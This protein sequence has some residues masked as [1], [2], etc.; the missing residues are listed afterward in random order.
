MGNNKPWRPPDWDNPYYKILEG[1]DRCV[2]SD[3][4]AFEF[5]AGAAAMLEGLKKEGTKYNIN[6]QG[7]Y[8]AKFEDEEGAII[9][10]DTA[11]GVSGTLVFIPDEEAKE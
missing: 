4:G 8:Y 3:Q 5:E 10:T 6:H 7:L 2:P 1:N 11:Y 9:F